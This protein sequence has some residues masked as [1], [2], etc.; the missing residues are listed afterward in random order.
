MDVDADRAGLR[1]ERC[2]SLVVQ[3]RRGAQAPALCSDCARRVRQ[4][5][6]FREYYAAHKERLLEKNRRWA[7]T[8]LVQIAQRRQSSKTAKPEER[9]TCVDCGRPVVRAARCRRCTTR[10]RYANDPTY[11]ARLRAAKQRWRERQRAHGRGD[12]VPA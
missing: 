1:C 6:Y 12:A 7:K 8:H 2:G 11:R 3:R 10:F 9:R 5:A 4:A